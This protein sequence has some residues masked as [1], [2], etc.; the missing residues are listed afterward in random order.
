MIKPYGSTVKPGNMAKAYSIISYKSL[1]KKET[2]E[3][4]VTELFG[5]AEYRVNVYEERTPH[6]YECFD[7]KLTRYADRRYLEEYVKQMKQAYRIDGVYF[8][9]S[10]G[11]HYPLAKF[12][13][14][15]S[16]FRQMGFLSDINI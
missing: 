9:R 15:N 14:Q 16:A 7:L 6:L 1:S 8:G 4:F 2:Y 12:R 11:N 3:I 5:D 10:C 13:E